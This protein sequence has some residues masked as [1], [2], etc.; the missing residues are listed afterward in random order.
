[1]FAS[2]DPDSNLKQ[3]VTFIASL[4]LQFV[5]LVALG[6]LPFP[7]MSGA[8]IRHSVRPASV[9]AIYFHRDTSATP[10]DPE[11][12]P[13]ASHPTPELPKEEAKLDTEQEVNTQAEAT[14]GSSG[15]GEGQGLA[16]FSSWSMNSMPLGFRI[17]HH[18]IKTALPVFTPDPPILHGGVPE[19]AR[20]KDVVVEVV[21][22]D[23]GSI[24][25][26][27]VLQAVGYGVEESIMQTLRR[28][29][30]VPA[31]VNGVAIASRRQL[32]FH[33]PG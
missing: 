24:V 3:R 17:P 2:L 31:K 29:I 33:F 20:G 15:D 23:Q 21:I 6:S 19:L 4:F 28:W 8:T 11:P 14:D 12:V 27:K 16:P 7:Q 25:Q 10:D 18:Q 5:V 32:R 9:T 22:D 26:A 13:A 30:F 1:M